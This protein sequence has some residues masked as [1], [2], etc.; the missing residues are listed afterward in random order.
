MMGHLRQS[1]DA[2]GGNQKLL[3]LAGDGSFCNR[4]C[5]RAT[6]DRT[7]LIARAPK[8]AVLCF[9]APPDSRRFYATDKFTPDQVRQDESRAWKE[10]KLFYRRPAQKGSLQGSGQGFLARRRRQDPVALDRG[11]AHSLSQAQEQQI[12]L[13]PTRLPVD[14]RPEKFRQATPADLF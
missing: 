12:V 5:F 7:E 3:V 2:A 8:D 13:P 10:T 4:T 9:Q 6:R 11:R 14:H 1:L